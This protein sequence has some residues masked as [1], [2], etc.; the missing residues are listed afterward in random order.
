MATFRRLAVYCGASLG[1]HGAYAEAAAVLGMELAQRGI[2]LVYGGGRVGLMGVVA[3]AA[4]GAGGH[5]IGVIPEKL[6]TGEIAHAGLTE[7]YVV[8]SMH[9]RK[10]MMANL[11]DGF[12]ALPGGWGTL[13]ELFEM[14]AWAQL[15]FHHKPIGL[16]NVRGYFDGLL[17]FLAHTTREGFAHPPAPALLVAEPTVAGLLGALAAR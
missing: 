14:S 6:Y 17:S 3:D 8:E 4:L 7:L 9:T 13:E 10:A 1:N 16:L 12:L 5:V 2:G 15:G 11:S